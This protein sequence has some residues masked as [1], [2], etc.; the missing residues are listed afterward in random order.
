M[1]V[2]KNSILS[3]ND[4]NGF[5]NRFQKKSNL[6]FE[7]DKID[8]FIFF[9]SFIL[10][11]YIWK[12]KKFESIWNSRIIDITA[13][14]WWHVSEYLSYITKNIYFHK[15]N[16]ID[17]KWCNNEII[18]NKTRIVNRTVKNKKNMYL[19]NHNHV[20]KLHRQIWW[21]RVNI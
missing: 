3:L 12:Y 1:G 19:K 14:I 4:F 13:Y 20:L 5:I 6:S 17:Y 7:S 9:K 2:L 21:I 8:L 18:P 11:G 16:G 10:S 15:C